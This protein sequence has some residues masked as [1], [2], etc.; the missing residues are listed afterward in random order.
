MLTIS[1]TT[2]NGG[3]ATK[4]DIR[5]FNSQNA[6]TFIRIYGFWDDTHITNYDA[7]TVS[8]PADIIQLEIPVSEDPL[9]VVD[10][11]NTTLAEDVNTWLTAD[12]KHMKQVCRRLLENYIMTSAPFSDDWST[13]TQSWS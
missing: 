12:G 13:A 7:G 10:D 9:L 3:I 11:E 6:K 8:S 5:E 1:K 2:R 4:W